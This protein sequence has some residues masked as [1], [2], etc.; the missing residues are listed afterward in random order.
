M[1]VF[2]CGMLSMIIPPLALAAFAAASTAGAGQIT[3]AWEAFRIGWIA[4]FLP[5]LFIYQNGPLAMS[6]MSDTALACA[7]ATIAVPLVTAGLVGHGR[8]RKRPL[9]PINRTASLVCAESLGEVLDVLGQPRRDRKAA[10][11]T[12]SL[13]L[14]ALVMRSTKQASGE[15]FCFRPIGSC[16]CAIVRSAD[17]RGSSQYNYC[18]Q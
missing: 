9:L 11:R 17:A 18:G 13:S 14:H 6:S 3:T 4:C 1:F 7:S 2:Y 10:P 5:I 8:R 16:D 15:E 12:E